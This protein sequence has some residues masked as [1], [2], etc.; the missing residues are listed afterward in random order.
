MAIVVG[1]DEAGYGPIL[2]PLVVSRVAFEIPDD[3]ADHCLWKLLHRSV[4]PRIRRREIRLPVADSKKLHHGPK[5]LAL[6]ERTALSFL[7]LNGQAIRTLDDLL[8]CVCPSVLLVLAGYPWYA[9]RAL[10]LPVA[11]EDAAI[12][13]HA[14]ALADDMQG[15]S[16]RWV[17]ARCEVMPEGH[18][19][20]MIEHTRNKATVLWTMTLALM[21]DL[22]HP[23]RGNRIDVH[24][25]RQGGRVSHARGLLTA[26][27]QAKL[28]IL[29]ETPEKSCY[30]MRWNST[31]DRSEA[32]VGVDFTVDGESH[33]LPIALASI[34]S[35]YLRELFMILFNRYWQKQV[36]SL[37][38]T[39]GYYQ[40]GI[41][42]LKDIEPARLALN[43]DRR[44][45]IRSR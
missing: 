41:R 18:F 11:C 5:G 39:A 35:K 27:D 19:N 34:F 12:A 14:H 42:F 29:E 44:L 20:R 30:R 21:N 3:R 36:D 23:P 10:P 38:R 32:V 6:L 22:I 13:I 26:F 16:M 2:G 17:D 24:I 37:E 15:Q 7:R 25:D 4:T 28:E 45:L 1:I 8:S 40:D 9:E 43:I 31:N 33:H